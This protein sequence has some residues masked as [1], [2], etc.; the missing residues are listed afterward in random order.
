MNAFQRASAFVQE[1]M[2]QRPKPKPD[3]AHVTVP[4]WLVRAAKFA[5]WVATLSLMYFLWLYTLDIAK[6][7]AASLHLTQVGTW[8]GNVNFWFPYIIGFAIVAFG[9]PYVAKIAI[10]TFMSLD[11]RQNFWPKCW[12]LVIALSV[13]L[14]VIAGTFSVQGDTL[15][16]RDRESAVAVEA[17]QQ[18]RA[19][20]EARIAAI[21]AELSEMMNNRNA[22]LAQAASV[23]AAEWE[24]SYIA[25]ARAT[26]DARLPMIERALGAARAADNL[27]AERQRLQGELA[28]APTIASVQ[29]EVVTERTSWI[30]DTLGWLEG[31]RAILL[32]LVMDVVALMMPW[33]AL[34]LEQARNRQMGGVETSG[35]APEGLR[36]EDLRDQ[37]N[38]TPQPMDPP[39]ETVHDAD[40]GEE[41]VRVQPK[42]R[43]YFRRKGKPKKGQPQRV[44]LTPDLAPDERGA[45]VDGGQRIGVGKDGADGVMIDEGGLSAR[46]PEREAGAN[47]GSEG[48][49]EANRGG[50]VP[51]GDDH[52]TAPQQ[53]QDDEAVSDQDVLL[54]DD[55][56]LVLADE[57]PTES[58]VLDGDADEQRDDG[59]RPD[60]ERQDQQRHDKSLISAK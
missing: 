37:P 33:I 34:R 55:D 40:T 46:E 56:L 59:N 21:T 15:M 54:S 53:R 19:A 3:P 49:E 13:S 48:G 51:N 11:W 18:G 23:G 47:T 36:I 25:Q 9:I 29:G 35:W 20:T 6:D 8:S 5:S 2:A 14:V 7:R 32:S 52:D 16:E 43:E 31:V 26:N 28:A 27:R 60:D 17:V 42:M 39:R 44:E 57:L 10:P 24:R 41:L 30:A 22:Y 45:K 58:V 12:A 1:R 38:V 50:V 4:A